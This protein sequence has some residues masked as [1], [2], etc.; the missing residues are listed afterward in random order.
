MPSRRRKKPRRALSSE[1]S[2]GPLLSHVVSPG[3]RVFGLSLGVREAG[4]RRVGARAR[5]RWVSGIIRTLAAG[6]SA[7]PACASRSLEDL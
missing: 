2:N 7:I 6:A 4:G 3:A 5:Q 1:P